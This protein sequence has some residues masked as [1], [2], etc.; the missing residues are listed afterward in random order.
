M[1]GLGFSTIC[2]LLIFLIRFFGVLT[3]AGLI[4][5]MGFFTILIWMAIWNPAETFLYGLHPYKTEI[6]NYKAM[7]SA[8]I[9]IEEE[10]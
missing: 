7:K 4:V 8:E 9:L 10:T 5:S 2:L 6:R 1:I 3:D